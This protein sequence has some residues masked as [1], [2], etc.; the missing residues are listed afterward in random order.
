MN[1]LNVRAE[2]NRLSCNGRRPDTPEAEL[3]GAFGRTIPYRDGFVSTVKFAGKSAWEFHQADEVL[4][5][6]EGNGT[7]LIIEDGGRTRPLGLHP[8]LAVVVPAGCWH[9]IEAPGGIA[10]FTVTPQP[11]HHLRADLSPWQR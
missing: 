1:T 4:Y 9:A 2:L 3:T 5:V 8:T 7:L 6:V 10:L 11:T